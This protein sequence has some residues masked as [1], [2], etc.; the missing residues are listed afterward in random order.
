MTMKNYLA[1]SPDEIRSI[2]TYL[3]DFMWERY[4]KNT[5]DSYIV[6]NWLKDSGSYTDKDKPYTRTFSEIMEATGFFNMYRI[7]KAYPNLI[8]YRESPQFYLEKAYNIYYKRVSTG[9]I[10][11]Y[12]EQQIPDMIEALKEE[13]M[14]TESANLQKKFALD[15]GRNMTRATYPYGSEFEY[16]NTGEEGAYAAAKALRTYYPADSLT[17]AAE[18]SMEMADWKTRAMRGI[19]PTWFHYSVPVFRG[20]EGWWNFQ[21]TASLAGYIMDDWLRYENDG[22]SVEQKAIAQQRNYAA[23]ISNFNAVNMGQISANSV[24]STSWRYSMYKGGT[25]TKDVYDGGSRVMSNGWNDFSGES[26]EGLYGSLLSISSDIVTD[27]I[28]GLFGYGALVTDEGNS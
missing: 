16:D 9:A 4:M 18:K 2:E 20:G 23:K 12:G 28:F 10:G 24:G 15:K 21:Y 19:Q 11:F 26:E 22:R 17:G 13:G 14:Q 25:G 8:E 5:Q 7:Q 3:I 1:P 6:A 27:P